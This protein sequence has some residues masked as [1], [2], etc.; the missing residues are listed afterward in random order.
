MNAQTSI[1][2]Q[3][4]DCKPIKYAWPGGYPVFYIAIEGYRNDTTGDLEMSQHD[5]SEFVCCAECAAKREDRILIASD[6]N[7]EDAS[8]YCDVCS[9]R[10]ESAYADDEAEAKPK[11]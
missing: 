10:I 11:S 6:V 2:I 1:D 9:E 4:W 7:W 8:L 5:R 3:T